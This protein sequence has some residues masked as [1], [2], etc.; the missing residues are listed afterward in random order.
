MS[1]KWN[2]FNKI[3]CIFLQWLKSLSISE[4]KIKTALKL[5][6]RRMH[7]LF[8]WCA[9]LLA[10]Y[11]QTDMVV[12]KKECNLYNSVANTLL[13][14]RYI[15]S[16]LLI[17]VTTPKVKIDIICS[18]LLIFYWKCNSKLTTYKFWKS[19]QTFMLLIVEL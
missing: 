1:T 11:W 18:F 7:P 16:C 9:K 4:I 12:V 6:T 17:T 5:F 19:L 13:I 3:A 2:C 15:R 8:K 14:Q 10:F